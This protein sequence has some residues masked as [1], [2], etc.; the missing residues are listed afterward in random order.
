MRELHIVQARSRQMC[1]SDV[2]TH[3]E[4][5]KLSS[6][7]EMISLNSPISRDMHYTELSVLPVH[8]MIVQTVEPYGSA[9]DLFG[10]FDAVPRFDSDIVK[11]EIVKDLSEWT[12]EKSF[13]KDMV[14][15]KE[16]YDKCLG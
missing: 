9:A 2:I 7:Y 3:R 13:F 14:I 11:P 1:L 16:T 15:K 8:V 6:R 10:I 12:I 5:P 4:M